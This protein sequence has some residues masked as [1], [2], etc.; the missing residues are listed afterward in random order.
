[1]PSA[2]KGTTPIQ[3]TVYKVDSRSWPEMPMANA[4]AQAVMLELKSFR[5]IPIISAAECVAQLQQQAHIEP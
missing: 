4:T 3:M 2:P 5:G 1:M